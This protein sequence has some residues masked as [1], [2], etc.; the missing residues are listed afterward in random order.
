MLRR[1]VTGFDQLAYD[2]AHLLIEV[3]VTMA[4]ESKAHGVADCNL[5]VDDA[6]THRA[7]HL[8]KFGL[9][10]DRAEAAGACADD[11]DGLLRMVFV[12]IGRDTRRAFLSTL[13]IDS[14]TRG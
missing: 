10:P 5:A 6:G 11:R 9:R 1:V 7:E 2:F 8:A 4:Q 14:C 13:G 3:R 12:A